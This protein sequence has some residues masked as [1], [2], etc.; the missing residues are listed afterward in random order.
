MGK[1]ED[2]VR[3]FTRKAQARYRAT[4]R[5]AVQDTISMAQRVR[6][7]TATDLSGISDV[8]SGGRM[9]IVTGFLRA[10]NQAAQR[11]MPSGPSDN[12]KNK[13]YPIDTQVAGEPVSVTLARWDPNT[14]ATLFVGWTANYARRMEAKYGF[15]QG[16]VE[17]WDQTVK[18]AVKKVEAGLG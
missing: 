8:P 17:Q 7:G 12:P 6:I 10:S 16:S 2:Q 5:L 9:P 4:A 18:K 15:L 3:E 11:I 14:Q 1:F 13:K